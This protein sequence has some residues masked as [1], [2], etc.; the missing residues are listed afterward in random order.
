MEKR[1]QE[2]FDNLGLECLKDII[3]KYDYLFHGICSQTIGGIKGTIVRA[4]NLG[5]NTIA[6][7]L[8]KNII[9]YKT[10]G[11][12]SILCGHTEMVTCICFTN[13]IFVSGSNDGEIRVWN[14]ET[15]E[16]SQIL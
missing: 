10:P 13:N 7:T 14:L 3:T 5:N 1:K 16:C 11:I 6:Y 15:R 9:I 2:I 8:D 12:M 4:I